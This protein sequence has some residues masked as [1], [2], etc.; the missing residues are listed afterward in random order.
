MQMLPA[1][2]APAWQ[3][4]AEHRRKRPLC[5]NKAKAANNVIAQSLHTG[6]RSLEQQRILGINAGKAET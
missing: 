5:Q 2:P 1:L 3:L 6:E 4:Q